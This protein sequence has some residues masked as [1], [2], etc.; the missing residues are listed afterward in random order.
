M[1]LLFFKYVGDGKASL[2]EV[3]QN[4]TEFKSALNDI[5]KRRYNQATK[6]SALFNNEMLYKATSRLLRIFGDY[7][8]TMSESKLKATCRTCRKQLKVLIPKQM[9]QRLQISLALVKADNTSEKVL[10]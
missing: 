6:K 10:K 5:E 3:K 1:Q 7:S 8:T 2:E 4:Q 9:L